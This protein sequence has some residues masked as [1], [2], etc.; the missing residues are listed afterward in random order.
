VVI[1]DFVKKIHQSVDVFTLLNAPVLYKTFQTFLMNIY[2]TE[3]PIFLSISIRHFLI[4]L[5][6]I[7]LG[8]DIYQQLTSGIKLTSPHKYNLFI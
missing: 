5:Q 8:T 7:C 1:I 6:S 4:K 3:Q 2:I